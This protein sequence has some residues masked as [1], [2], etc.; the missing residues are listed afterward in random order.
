M[1]LINERQSQGTYATLLSDGTIRVKCDERDADAVKREYELADGTKGVKFERVFTS[2]IGKIV[3]MEIR[4]GKFGSQLTIGLKDDEDRYILCV[5]AQSNF[6]SDILKK[7]PNIDFSREIV[8]SPFS[9]TSK[10]TNK[11][12]K[13]VTLTQDGTKLTN[14]FYDSEA[15]KNINNFPSPEGDTK[16]Y[17]S[18]KWKSYFMNVDIFLTDYFNENVLPKLGSMPAT[19]TE[20]ISIDDKSLDEIFS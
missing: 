5:G 10:E 13:G 6:Y 18:A 14:F 16:K 3:T 7:S 2:I 12:V 1:G 19:T 11:P 17:T 15:K 20:E 9:F 8:I 4:D